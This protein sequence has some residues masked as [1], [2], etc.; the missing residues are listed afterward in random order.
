M[1]IRGRFEAAIARDAVACGPGTAILLSPTLGRMLRAE[2]GNAGL[3]LLLK[4]FALRRQL[5]AL[6]G[7]VPKEPVEGRARRV[8]EN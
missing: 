1:P 6:L 7:E 2:R 5:A 4:G 3:S 8:V